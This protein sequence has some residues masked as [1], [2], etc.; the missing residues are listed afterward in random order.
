MDDKTDR[1]ALQF[2]DWVQ[3]AYAKVDQAQLQLR[4]LGMGK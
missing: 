3:Q 2:T 1:A 4:S